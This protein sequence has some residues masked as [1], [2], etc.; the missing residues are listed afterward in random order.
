VRVSSHK[1]GPIT[2]DGKPYVAPQIKDLIPNDTS[3]TMNLLNPTTKKFE[4]VDPQNYIGRVNGQINELAYKSA[5]LYWL[6]GEERYARFATDILQQW[7]NAAVYQYPIKGPGRV[8]YLNI[9]TLG[10]EQIKPLILA[11]DFLYTYM[12]ENNHPLDNFQ[13]VFERVAWTLAFRGYA[14]N[15]WYAAESST[16]V[17]AA[18]SLKDQKQ[19]DYYLDFFLNKDTVVDGCGQLA[20]PSTV[21]RW[22]TPDG[23][24]KE[25]GGYHNY[26]VSKLIESAM[27]LENNGVNIFNKYPVL[28]DAAFVMLKYSFPN[29]TVSAFGD[30]GRPSQSIHCLES[31]IKMAQFYN[32]PILND[33]IGSAHTLQGIG[34]YDRSTTGIE[35]LLCYL[36]ELPLKT[37]NES[38][39]WNRTEKLDFASCYLQR[40]SMNPMTGLMCVVQGSTY[41]HNHCNGMAIELYGAGTVLG[42]DPG[43]GPNYEHPLH[44]GYY[45]QWAAHNTVVAGGASSST[46]FAGQ[47]GSKD[48][49]K[50]ELISMEP[51]AGE[52][53]V[54]QNI[55]Y[56]HTK[57]FDKSTK[58]NQSRLLSIIRVDDEYGFYVDLY[59]SDNTVSNDYLYHNIGEKVDFYSV[60]GT[61]LETEPVEV[62]PQQKEDKP[63]FRFFTSVEKIRDYKESLIALFSA[64]ELS[65]G[66]GYMKMW[67]PASKDRDYYTALSPNA[68]TAPKAYS[69]KKVPVVAIRTEKPAKN[70]PFIVVYEPT[71]DG[72]KGGVIQSVNQEK[73]SSGDN[74]VILSIKTKNGGKYT[75]VNSKENS[76]L[77]IGEKS[78]SADWGVFSETTTSFSLYLGN[79]LFIENEDYKIEVLGGVKGSASLEQVSDK[80]IISS[81][82]SVRLTVKNSKL[83]KQICPENP[84]LILEKGETIIDLK[85]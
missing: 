49:G 60:D 55:S 10:D 68:K 16:L 56:T 71:T 42:I 85:K 83:K 11:H 24:W 28:F 73:I 69:T 80:L 6:T 57:Y 45:A 35:G 64:E 36:P 34:K 40:N 62:Y 81:A 46:P 5:V 75:L 84:Y 30:T 20:M 44:V 21:K 52:D 66:K 43:C 47:A 48:I 70:D 65:M 51:L 14:G 50:V 7:V 33:L 39:L 2:S 58:T 41:N 82:N 67:M 19:Q 74:G 23:H 72:L 53:A 13:K 12:K 9:Q 8:G 29:L 18:L 38:V 32:L 79:G 1:R 4:R 77:N 63:G 31:A 54:S 26:P 27:M 76:I 59:R 61:L 37:E 15:N 22:F 17:A 78:C 25:P 3:M